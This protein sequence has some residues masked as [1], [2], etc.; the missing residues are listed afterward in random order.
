MPTMPTI[1]NETTRIAQATRLPATVRA[2]DI[3]AALLPRPASNS[4]IQKCLTEAHNLGL[5]K[6]L[7]VG[8]HYEYHG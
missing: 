4:Q 2:P 5:I 6:R 1:K 3:A 7:Q 8:D